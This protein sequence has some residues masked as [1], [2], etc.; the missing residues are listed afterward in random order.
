[1]ER[2]VA[3]AA[4]AGLPAGGRAQPAEH[5]HL[6]RHGRRQDDAAQHPVELHLRQGAHR[7]DR[8]R[9]RADDAAAARGAPRDAPGQHR[10]P[11]RGEGARPGDQLPAYAP[12]SH[13]RRRGPRRRGARHAAGHEH[14]PRRVAHDDSRQH[15]AR[16]AVSSRH[17]GRDGQPEHSR[18]SAVRQQVASAVDILV[19]VSRQADGTRKITA[20]LRDHRHGGRR[21]HD[22][23]HLPVREDGRGA[24]AAA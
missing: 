15:A 18:T 3:H 7:H 8:G 6:R 14:R 13:R 12:R 5:H 4:D 1:M 17:D 24:P 23:G 20:S 11:R 9:G 19:Q 10:R 21:D 22:A 16:R 2:A